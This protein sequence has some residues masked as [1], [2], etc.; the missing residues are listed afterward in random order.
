MPDCP[1]TLFHFVR[2]PRM[3]VMMN[4]SCSES[5]ACFNTNGGPILLGCEERQKRKREP[6]MRLFVQ[7]SVFF[8]F[9]SFGVKRKN[10]LLVEQTPDQFGNILTRAREDWVSGDW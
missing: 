7:L 8:T 10:M 9:L 1:R 2:P 5:M 3:C 6:E 4:Y